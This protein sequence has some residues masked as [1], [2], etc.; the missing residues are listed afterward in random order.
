MKKRRIAEEKLDMFLTKSAQ[1]L[2]RD[3]SVKVQIRYTSFSKG[4]S[5]TYYYLR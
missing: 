5:L 2:K 4:H 3:P 1:K